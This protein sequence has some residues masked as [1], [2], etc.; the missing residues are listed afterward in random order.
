VFALGAA[1][2]PPFSITVTRT[3]DPVGAGSCPDDCSL[4]QAIA[5]IANDGT[6]T[7]PSGTYELTQGQLA[8]PGTPGTPKTITINSE[9]DDARQT[10]IHQ[11]GEHRVLEVSAGDTLY[12]TGVTVT[13]GDTVFDEDEPNAGVGGGIWV[14]SG[15]TL[16]LSESTVTDNSATDSGGGIDT[17]G[18]LYVDSSTIEDN[19]V[20]G[21]NGIGG[22]IDDFGSTVSITSTTI[23]GNFAE[24]DGGGLYA[25]NDIT[26]LNDT[27][28]LNE[29]LGDGTANDVGFDSDVDV[30]TTNTIF[31]DGLFEG[32][33]NGNP[34]CDRGELDS[35]GGN[36]SDD[37]SCGLGAANDVQDSDEIA[38]GPV[39]D[40]GGPTDTAAPDAGSAAIDGGL[41]SPDCAATDQRGVRR[42]QG[43]HCDIGAFET[44][45]MSQQHSLLT[46]GDDEEGRGQFGYS[47]ALSAD[48]NT[49]LVG[50]PRDSTNAGAAF[51]FVRDSS[52]SDGSGWRFNAELT[53]N[54]DEEIGNGEFGTSVA[55]SADGD[56]AIV[57]APDDDSGTGAAWVFT[58]SDFTSED[59]SEQGSKLVAGDETS[60]AGN[61]GS[62]V[63]LSADGSIA[64]IGGPGDDDSTGAAWVFAGQDGVLTQQGSKLLDPEGDAGDDAG[65]SVA[66]SA[67]GS[68]GLV[69]EP[70]KFEGVGQ[71]QVFY[72]TNLTQTGS[73]LFGDEGSQ[74]FGTSVALSAD[75]TTALVGDPGNR[76]GDDVGAGWVF[77]GSGTSWSSG[78]ELLVTDE[79]N[80]SAGLGESVALSADG[81]TALLGGPFDG[82]EGGVGAAW[83]FVHSDTWQES[84]KLTPSGTTG[85]EPEFG[86]SVALSTL[87]STALV[88]GPLDN[89]DVGTAWPFAIGPIVSR[90]DATDVYD[91]TANLTG[92]VDES[93]SDTSYTIEY[94]TTE[95][96]GQQLGPFDLGSDG[97]GPLG[98][99]QPLTGLEPDTDYHFRLVATNA[100]GTTQGSDEIFTT[101][102]VF[103]GTAG[104]ALPSEVLG[105]GQGC[106]TLG[107]T[108]DWGDGSPTDSPDPDCF[109]VDDSEFY[110]IDGTHTYAAAGHY[111]I[112]TDARFD[113]PSDEF[114]AGA[115]IAPVQP[116]VSSPIATSVTATGATLGAAINPNA[117]DTTYIVEYGT[118][119]A[120]GQQTSSTD[121][122]V[123][124]QA[125][126]RTVTGLQPSTTYH[127]RI[128]ATNA[129]GTTNGSDQLFTTAAAPA[130]PAAPS[131]GGG[132][133]GGST[134][135]SPTIAGE[136][137]QTVNGSSAT[138]TATITPNGAD[139]SYV[140]EYGTSASYGQQTA[141]VDIG[142]GAS[143]QSANQ[144]ISGLSPSQTYHFQFV[145]TNSVGSVSGPDSSFITTTGGTGVTGGIVPPPV[146]G[147][148]AD[149]FP[150]LGTVLVNGKPLLVGEQIPFGATVDTTNGTVVLETLDDGVLQTMQFA[151]G[152]FVVTQLQDGTTLLVL[153]GG[154][155]TATCGSGK[156]TRQAASSLNAHTVRSLWGNG[157]GHFS[158]K[159]KY[160]AATVR[161]TNFHVVDRC[162]GTFVHVRRGIV[163]V[164]ITSTGK[165]VLVTVGQ[166]YLAD[167]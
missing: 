145:A 119:T 92:T 23:A 66:L 13:G 135:A 26:L 76:G 78:T 97:D 118:T 98:V 140:V 126:S 31:D 151:T 102:P 28:S 5:A 43:P 109:D 124:Q 63:A 68:T 17:D 47:V 139:T 30:A 19:T 27:F 163:A 14:D 61:F 36:I 6:I 105:S 38:L 120:Y 32:T 22:G 114:G 72:G 55:L 44:T 15:A 25:G 45:A 18:N 106:P 111:Q 70:G 34:E 95:A 10:T 73:A 142:A 147:V 57:G 74:G 133:G 96:Y 35:Q 50:T 9:G 75:G 148:S 93:G 86:S 37:D 117:A 21:D 58:R 156:T 143:G 123:T 132:G 7:L 164:L 87:A 130:A 153:T 49:A 11:S 149:L 12:L 144:V 80:G 99:S 39:Q 128:D 48:G 108:V 46:G 41:D 52:E 101:G 138:V 155:F 125:V 83:L 64:L 54:A 88:G 3:D 104:S 71:A 53:P 129:G 161:G 116:A 24:N 150:F 29:T 84:A 158:V 121:I 134:Q 59:W 103:S 20:S 51:V 62:S 152:I 160:A 89:D 81:N 113:G 65:A 2:D 127:F 33:N 136:V 77:T 137:L 122:G 112:T 146:Q 16:N 4:R 8:T 141:P 90:E 60:G 107:V 100:D 85:P 131:G 157:H 162:D 67:D 166:S 82:G 167:A 1:A 165:T 56:T 115:Q 42:P 154:S 69:G 94:G 91:T 110:E 159:G 40:N 79:L